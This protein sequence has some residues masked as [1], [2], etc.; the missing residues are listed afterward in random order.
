MTKTSGRSFPARGCGPKEPGQ[1][2]ERSTGFE[3]AIRYKVPYITTTTA[4][5]AA[6]EGIAAR[7]AAHGVV[8]P[9]QSY[10][11]SLR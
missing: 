7:R 9:L 4:A 8:R 2:K 6:A 10:H 11:S 1:E 5:Q 3:P